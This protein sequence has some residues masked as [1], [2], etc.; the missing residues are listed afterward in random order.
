MLVLICDD[1]E[2]DRRICSELINK[3]GEENQ[4]SITIEEFAEG[5]Q[6]L[7]RAEDIYTEVDLI[8]MDI[9]MPK[10]NGLEATEKL[11]EM[12]Y[13]GDIV[14]YTISDEYAV[15]GYDLDVMNYIVKDRTSEKRFMSILKKAVDR[16][17]TRERDMMILQC[18]GENRCIAIDEIHYFEIRQRIVTV[19]YAKETFDFYSTMMR[20]EEE[21]F[22]KGFVRTHKSFLVRRSEIAKMTA[23]KI[24]LNDGTELPAGQTYI[25]RIRKEEGTVND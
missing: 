17:N 19:H 18:A 11:R 20:L 13:A 7:F 12:G 25:A 4:I 2:K 10:V 21:I 15:T 22:G 23:R 6:L 5:G 3:F 8:Y 1:K 24:T 14:F 16:T 9:N